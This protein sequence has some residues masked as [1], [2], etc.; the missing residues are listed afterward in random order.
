MRPCEG[1][2]RLG[3]YRA[4]DHDVGEVLQQRA[5][6]RVVDDHGSKPKGRTPGCQRPC[7]ESLEEA[8][9]DVDD[10]VVE[11]KVKRF[12]VVAEAEKVADYP[13]AAVGAGQLLYLAAWI[14][15]GEL[16]QIASIAFV[17][18]VVPQLPFGNF[19]AAEDVVSKETEVTF[20][21]GRRDDN[22]LHSTSSEH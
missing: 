14:G 9:L 17:A 5:A 3:R 13:E 11:T 18:A 21:T 16:A 2:H 20:P 12:R 1:T 4:F 6:N 15:R 10:V 22:Q 8:G 19:P 7:L